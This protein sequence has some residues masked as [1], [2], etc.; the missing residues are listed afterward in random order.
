MSSLRHFLFIINI[1]ISASLALRIALPILVDYDEI[2]SGDQQLETVSYP[3]LKIKE[4]PVVANH[5]SLIGNIHLVDTLLKNNIN[6]VKIFSPEHG[7]R[8]TADAG[9]TI[10]NGTVR[11]RESEFFHFMENIKNHPIQSSGN[12]NSCF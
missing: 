10:S 4:W 9:E 12:R 11:I 7:F 5:A 2:I 8:G 3:S 6:I 1:L